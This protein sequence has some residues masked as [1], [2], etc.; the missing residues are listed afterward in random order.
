MNNKW[1]DI[2]EIQS[3]EELYTAK[4]IAEI[5]GMNVSTVNN[6][7]LKMGLPY[8]RIGKFA[9][10]SKTQ[11]VHWLNNYQRNEPD[12][13]AILGKALAE[14]ARLARFGRKT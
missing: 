7:R 1:D 6:W 11:V 3:L 2:P 12:K 5:I 13:T 10:F 14:R 8:V 4:G 9:Y